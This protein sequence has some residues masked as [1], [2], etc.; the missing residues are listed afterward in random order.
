M[1][2][3][4]D[5]VENFREKIQCFLNKFKVYQL[6]TQLPELWLRS[7]SPIDKNLVYYS[8]QTLNLPLK[9]FPS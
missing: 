5:L 8:D 9:L 6:E 1:S 4:V 2:N 7:R 3:K